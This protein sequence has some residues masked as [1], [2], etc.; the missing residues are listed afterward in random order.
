MGRTPHL[1]VKCLIV[2]VATVMWRWQ[3]EDWAPCVKKGGSYWEERRWRRG[4]PPP[5]AIE[6]AQHTK[7][8]AFDSGLRR[9]ED[10]CSGQKIR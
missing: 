5:V 8:D 3:K 1:C 10:H 9:K 7:P 6:G 4:S 2:M